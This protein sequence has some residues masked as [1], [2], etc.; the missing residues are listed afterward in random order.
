MLF[1]PNEKNNSDNSKLNNSD[2]DFVGSSFAV[3]FKPNDPANSV[4]DKLKNSEDKPNATDSIKDDFDS[5]EFDPSI[6]AFKPIGAQA[7]A[8]KAPAKEEPAKKDISPEAAVK[9]T[10]PIDFAISEADKKTSPFVNAT[11][12]DMPKPS[13]ID[14]PSVTSENTVTKKPESYSMESEDEGLATFGTVASGVD[15]FK[16]AAPDRA[17]VS[18]TPVAPAAAKTSPAA[19][20][21]PA[22]SASSTDK[23]AYEVSSDSPAK[24]H[25]GFAS[26]DTAPASSRSINHE[27]RPTA[28]AEKPAAGHP[29]NN[30]TQTPPAA[31]RTEAHT[32]SS[33]K[34]V[35]ASSAPTA[36]SPDKSQLQN[37]PQSNS[38]RAY[39]TERTSQVAAERK[40]PS[41][42][43]KRPASATQRPGGASP[44][45]TSGYTSG[46]T[47]GSRTT[48]TK[49]VDASADMSSGA[50]KSATHDN[51]KTITAVTTVNKPKRSRKTEKRTKEPGLGGIITLVVI[52]A[53]FIAFVFV[54]DNTKQISALFGG[55][56]LTETVP[57][58]SSEAS[59]TEQ[60]TTATEATTT[61]TTKEET[62]STSEETTT[63]EA[64]ETS[65]DETTTTQETTT[66]SAAETTTKET[67]EATTT[68]LS[69]NG[70]VTV[71]DFDTKLSNFT[72]TSGGFKFDVK[73]TNKSND[74]ASLAASINEVDFSFYANKKITEVKS[75]YL[76][77]T[78]SGT[79][80]VGTPVDC[81]IE[82]GKSLT[83]TVYVSTES[84][85][86]HFGYNSCFFD[87][88]T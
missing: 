30:T 5:F 50:S 63:S 66:T 21:S 26:S 13:D 72:T 6:S 81:T 49:P 68:S 62:T 45:Q 76:D 14:F 57:T 8:S 87:W 80:F 42:P 19:D 46:Y 7:A 48:N 59:Q 64:A 16:H 52:I 2:D 25:N 34:N 61:A 65:D 79:E 73:L 71:T 18:E 23:Q 41:A 32:D 24:S 54:L 56:K 10:E 33:P 28:S 83:F 75:D 36:A 82:A 17:S 31:A 3:S 4:S 78:G 9:K 70:G 51:Q 44:A 38:G 29:V 39:N 69:A 43:I 67:T 86:S 47:S 22:A 88:N 84:A 40:T 37:R 15:A 20:A 27:A 77:F 35:R 12:P 53:I 85:V 11:K 60:T 74:D 58:I 55:N 1:D